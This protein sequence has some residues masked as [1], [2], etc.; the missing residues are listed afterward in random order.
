MSLEECSQKQDQERTLLTFYNYE[1]MT[2]TQDT[3]LAKLPL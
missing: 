3:L 2:E 1:Q